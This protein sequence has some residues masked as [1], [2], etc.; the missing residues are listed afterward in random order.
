MYRIAFDIGG[1]FTDFV[2][3]DTRDGSTAYWKVPTSSGSPDRA[4]IA[5]MAETLSNGRAS[6]DDIA[7]LL[8][9][10]TVATNAV[11]E[12]DG[13]R[14]ALITTRGF[15]D[16]VLMGR[17]KRPDTNDMNLEK[18]KPVVERCDI[19]EL[20]ER[21]D[22]GGAIITP[23]AVDELDALVST[24]ERGD[25][26]AVA[27]MFMHSY[28]N[29]AHEL[30][31]GKRLRRDLPGIPV[32]LSCEV[33][34]KYR[35]YERVTTTTVNAYVQ[36]IVDAYL[37]RL[38]SAFASQGIGCDL[39]IMQ[40][41][42]GLVSPAVARAYPVRIV[43]SGPAAGV[44][45]CAQVAR[46]EG[47]DHVLTFDMGGTTAK[48]GAIDYGEPIIVPTFEVDTI[49]F[50]KGSGLPLN[51]TAIE[52]LEIG[53]GGGSIAEVSMGLIKVGPSSASAIPGP[54]CYAKGG[55]RPTITDADVALGYLDP[56]FFNGGAMR[57]D[58]EAARAGIAEHI[59]R[60]L[61]L[62]GTEA[63]W[64]IYSVANSNL[65]GAMRVVSVERGRDPRQHVMIA[66]GG[67]G[68]LRAA[69][70]ARSMGVPKVLVPHGAGVGSAI[71]LLAAD[72][73]L[74]SSLTRLI[75]IEKGAESAIQEVFAGL[76]ERLRLE[77]EQVSPHGSPVVWKRSCS[78]RYRGQGYEIR[79]DLPDC[80]I[81]EG[82]MTAAREAFE[83]AYSAQY[84]Y[85]DAGASMDGVDWHLTAL[86]PRSK[87]P[88][89][90]EESRTE[91]DRTVRSRSAYFPEA[92][93]FL[94]TPVYR[95]NA[96]C[97]DQ[98]IPGPALIED[99]ESTTIVLP[100]DVASVSRNGHLILT[101]NQK[102]N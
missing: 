33:T 47:V 37:G 20:T 19:F 13:A 61:G 10:T 77:L 60:R 2:M 26:S 39:K 84:G 52:L 3:Q 64:G 71:G 46:D 85:T 53:S 24:I 29:S 34:P 15:R 90:R 11:L 67:S 72:Q 94:E 86:V 35:E 25:F 62:S 27:V 70:L 40:S 7:E 43:E 5:A 18:Q 22:A 89:W 21:I 101:I 42:G 58:I 96:L 36:P 63:A 8:H 49:R 65:E 6:R 28:A 100:G 83:R 1:T 78:M 4:V 79:V 74:D 55:K 76:E 38:E 69:R 68:P 56:D 48:L 66:F 41:N 54:I 14:I 51:I 88:S 102:K 82:F 57:L 81:D 16:I 73:K 30:E 80:V 98:T 97:S 17:Q 45:M 44:L 12:R 9:A 92:G 32:S 50:R 59:G 91:T 99:R 75:P 87:V 93:G 31:V 23:L 95:R